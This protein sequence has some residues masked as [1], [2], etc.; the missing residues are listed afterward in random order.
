MPK[1]NKR[2]YDFDEIV[3]DFI[4]YCTNKDLT[5][6]LWILTKNKSKYSYVVD[7][8]SLKSNNT[9]ARGDFGE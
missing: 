9:S 7:V 3:N 1:I 5:K 4:I 6:K 8:N 2:I